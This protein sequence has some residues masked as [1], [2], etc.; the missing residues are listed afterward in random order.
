[1]FSL[2]SRLDRRLRKKRVLA[3]FASVGAN[4]IFDPHSSF[5]T[6]E[7]IS[8]GD[9]VFIGEM[10]HLAGVI[11]IGSNVMFGPRPVIVAGNHIF[12][13]CG[14]SVRFLHPRGDENSEPIYIEDE[15]WCGACAV[16]LGGVTLGI[17]SVIGAGSVVTK[18]IPPYV[19]AAGNYARP[20]RR[21]FDDETLHRHLT[22]LGRN[23]SFAADVVDRRTQELA[24]WRLTELPVTDRTAD[25][26]RVSARQA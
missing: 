22:E 8:I 18:S 25:Y 1:M 11:A 10:A 19:I 20:M 7:T 4:F 13:V 16:I 23:E 2:I 17:G 5:V 12:A 3:S 6:P 15:A 24:A 26:A 21:I 14:H 9:N